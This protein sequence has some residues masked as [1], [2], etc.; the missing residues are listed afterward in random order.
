MVCIPALQKLHD[1]QQD[2]TVSLACAPLAAPT[3]CKSQPNPTISSKLQ[4]EGQHVYYLSAR[5]LGYSIWTG[6][7]EHWI[8]SCYWAQKLMSW[9]HNFCNCTCWALATWTCWF[10]VI[11]LW[12]TRVSVPVRNRILMHVWADWAWCIR[13]AQ[14]AWGERQRYLQG[15]PFLG[16]EYAAGVVQLRLAPL[17]CDANK[18]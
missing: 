9:F 8:Y 15:A 17:T 16:L 14:F 2:V 13:H 18:A 4:L 6:N 1:C 3:T 7:T 5:T 10:A 12:L 11:L